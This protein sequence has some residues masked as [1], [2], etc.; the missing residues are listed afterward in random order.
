MSESKGTRRVYS[1]DELHS[2]RN[3]CS[4]PKLREAIEERDGDDAEL[5]KGAPAGHAPFLTPCNLPPPT[6]P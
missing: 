5:V 6:Q 4:V 2:L 1:A 3:A